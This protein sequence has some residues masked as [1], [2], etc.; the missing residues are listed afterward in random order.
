VYVLTSERLGF[1][2]FDDADFSDLE[3]LDMDPEV[4]AHFPDGI[5]THAQIQARIARSKLSIESNGCP[6]FA[7]IELATGR[8]AGRAGFGLIE[9]GEIEVGYVFLKEFWGHGLAQESLRAL[10]A[11]ARENLA[12][13]RIVAYAPSTHSASLNVMKKAGMRYLRTDNLR[14]VPCDFY[15]YLL[16]PPGG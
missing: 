7:V 10:L 1:R 4:R 13:P 2:S 11:W 6:D 16:L 15:Q 9:G 12:V 5:A 8:F 3:R 14:G